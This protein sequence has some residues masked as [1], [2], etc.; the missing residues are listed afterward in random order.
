MNDTTWRIGAL[1]EATG[2][3]VRTLHHYEHLGLLS[4]GRTDG[5]HRL[6]DAD[7]VQR[8]YRVRALRELGLSLEEVRETLEQGSADLGAVLRAHLARTERELARLTDLR[9]RLAQ[10]CGQADGPVDA[11][12]LLATIEAMS[13]LTHHA[14]RRRAAGRSPPD[15]EGAWR[16]LGEALRAHLERGDPP[17]SPP[18]QALA[19]EAQA[20]IRRFA[21]DDPD[22]LDALAHLRQ[23]GPPQDL[24]GWDPPLFRYLDRALQTLTPETETC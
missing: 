10:V 16:R 24:A 13:L 9:G 15:M 5:N 11:Q 7:D 6:Y 22:T 21:E 19:R 3:T 20:R 12:A 14:A 17:S 8:L 4:P 2:L 18:V 23:A 1:A